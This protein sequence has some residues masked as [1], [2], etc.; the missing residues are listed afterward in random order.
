MV[1]LDNGHVVAGGEFSSIGGV[2]ASNIAEWD[3][4]NWNTLGAGLN[5]EV[6]DLVQL[7]SGEVVAAGAFSLSGSTVLNRIGV[8]DGA[9]W[10]WLDGGASDEVQALCVA[11]NGD[12]VAGGIF[13]SIGSGPVIASRVARWNGVSWSPL[14]GGVNA[15]VTELE[16]SGLGDVFVAGQFNVA[17]GVSVRRLA[18][19]D[20]AQWHALAEGSYGTVGFLTRLRDGRVAASGVFTQVNPVDRV[21]IW[22]GAAWQAIGD[23]HPYGDFATAVGVV[24]ANGEL[25]L[26]SSSSNALRRWAGGAWQPVSDPA[27]LPGGGGGVRSV[28]VTP[29]GGLFAGGPGGVAELEVACPAVVVS[30]PSGCVSPPSL[31]VLHATALPWI[32]SS[33]I[34]QG[35][36]LSATAIIAVVNGFAPFSFSLAAVFQASLS[37]CTLLVNPMFIDA[38]LATSGTLDF[39]VEIPF[40]VSLVGVTALY[41]QM[42]EMEFGF[43]SVRATNSLAVTCGAY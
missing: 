42:V 4:A 1:R 40:S 8:W 39:V 2:S 21:A 28:V 32:G 30:T 23:G 24:A 29:D 11:A 27:P 19:W 43:T 12:L 38:G 36:N 14:G 35:Q 18:R 26:A 33:L 17:G 25:V 6:F 22:D 5:G 15:E 10:T 7:P 34:T 3:G 16:V 9:V 37:G 13:Q 20:G 41:Q 31:P